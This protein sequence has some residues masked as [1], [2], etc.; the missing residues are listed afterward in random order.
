[1]SMPIQSR[2]PQSYPILAMISNSFEYVFCSFV[3]MSHS[4]HY[5][6]HPSPLCPLPLHYHFHLD[7][8]FLFEIVF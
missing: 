1:M 4:N 3:P 6:H 7:Y 5:H 2:Y 8:R